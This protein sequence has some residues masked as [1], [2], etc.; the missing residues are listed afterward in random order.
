MKSWAGLAG[1]STAHQFGQENTTAALVR[2]GAPGH[3][4]AA[5]SSAPSA[6]TSAQTGEA[7]PECDN[8]AEWNF[9]APDREARHWKNSTPLAPLASA[10]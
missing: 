3:P 10:W 6:V 9:S 4:S 2:T 8:I 1:F 5:A 7:W